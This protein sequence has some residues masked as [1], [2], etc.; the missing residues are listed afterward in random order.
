MIMLSNTMWTMVTAM[1]VTGGWARG[2]EDSPTHLA[3]SANSQKLMNLAK[4]GT[5]GCKNRSSDS[6]TAIA[7]Q[8]T[9]RRSL[10]AEREGLS[11]EVILAQLP[12]PSANTF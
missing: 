10:A 12:L 8:V 3:T 4:N 5:T 11:V 2:M 9:N 6:Q 1:A 7:Y